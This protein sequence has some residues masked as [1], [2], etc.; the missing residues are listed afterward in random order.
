MKE[1]RNRKPL[2]S[3]EKIMRTNRYNPLTE[4]LCECA[5]IEYFR[6]KWTR[7]ENL[8]FVE[9]VVGIPRY[10]M[11]LAVTSDYRSNL[12][13]EAIDGVG[14]FLYG[15][16]CDLIH[17]GIEPDD[18]MEP[19]TVSRRKDGT[20][21]KERDIA[22]LCITHQLL[23][24]LEKLMLEPLLK[25]RITHTQHASIPCRGQTSIKRQIHRYLASG[26]IETEAFAKTDVVHAY[27]N[28][29][30]S[31]CIDIVKKESPRAND[32]II[33]LRYLEKLAPGGHLIIGG[34][35]DAW[36]FN[37]VASYAL[38]FMES[39]GR[40]RRGK[41]IKDISRVSAYMDDFVILAKTASGIQRCVRKTRKFMIENLGLDIVVKVD[42]TPT[43]R[44][45]DSAGYQ[46][47][48]DHCI[49]RKM[50]W[51]R[52]RR[53]LLKAEKELSEIGTLR[54]ETA[55]KIISYNG[56]FKQTNSQK[57]QE[58][59]EVSKLMRIARRVSRFHGWLYRKRRKERNNALLKSV[60][61]FAY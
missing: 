5:V 31:L 1:L 16:V 44:L 41:F 47:G 25:A 21:G 20:T 28:T 27:Q 33:L 13:G 59:Y 50:N 58:K 2:Y 39:Q 45:I 38:R 35:L 6:H 7:H 18:F 9:K 52:I 56:Y 60:K 15:V 32:A 36:L 49:I 24:H 12:I 61:C 11:E 43:T 48:K 8:E 10:Q 55:R 51:K 29:S 37:L 23:E 4:N 34:Y 17:E 3:S 57:L 53:S 54:I 19:V 22:T 40:F 30:Y 26:A 42:P 46:I 14:L